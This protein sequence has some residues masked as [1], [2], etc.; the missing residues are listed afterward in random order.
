MP[1]NLFLH[2]KSFKAGNGIWKMTK[3]SDGSWIFEFTD[4]LFSMLGVGWA[5]NSAMIL[6][7][8]ATF[9]AHNTPVTELPHMTQETSCTYLLGGSASF[10]FAIALLFAGLSST[11][12]SA[13]AAGSIFAGI[14]Q[15]PFDIKD[16]HSRTGVIISLFLAAVIILLIRNP[17]KGL[18]ISQMILSMQLPVTIFLQIYLTSSEKVMGKY[19]NTLLNKILLYSVAGIVTLLNVFLLISFFR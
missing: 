11:I 8:A 18:I 6:L 19:K 16:N 9:Y 13:M 2:T 10:V 7:A 15:E 17:L 3:P 12:T 14:Y 1:H 5:I 4:T